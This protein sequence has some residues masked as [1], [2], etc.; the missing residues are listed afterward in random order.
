[1]ISGLAS[2][3]LATPSGFF[4][5]QRGCLLS[6]L[7]VPVPHNFLGSFLVRVNPRYVDF[8]P[9]FELP[10]IVFINNCNEVNYE[11]SLIPVLLL[12]ISV[13]LI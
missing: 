6:P 1:L 2:L 3:S 9:F 11:Q 7:I 12:L 8:V 4:R 13:N 10:L 5:G